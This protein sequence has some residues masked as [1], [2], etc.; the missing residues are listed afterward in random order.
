MTTHEH[1]NFSIDDA[2]DAQLRAVARLIEG[3]RAQL[4]EAAL[5]R[6][7]A[8][9]LPLVRQDAARDV[10]SETASDAAR[11][12]PGSGAAGLRLVGE[13]REVQRTGQREVPRTGQRELPRTGQR[14]ALGSMRKAAAIVLMVGG[15]AAALVAQRGASSS[16]PE[17]L[18]AAR[19]QRQGVA[20]GQAIAL[21]GTGRTTMTDDVGAGTVQPMQR[22]SDVLL[23]ESWLAAAEVPASDAW[24]DSAEGV[25]ESDESSDGTGESELLDWLDSTRTRGGEAL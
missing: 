10:A 16:T 6:I 4:P 14:E 13:G 1:D 18:A 20:S 11:L 9:T 7:I 12:L 25:L 8:G 22:D 17:A 15:A 5:A 3:Q 23:W 19:V 24:D 2:S 21:Q